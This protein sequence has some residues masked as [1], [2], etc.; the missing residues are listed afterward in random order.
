[1]NVFR[2]FIL[3]LILISASIT[4]AG[5]RAL[6]L[7]HDPELDNKD[8]LREIDR[9]IQNKHFAE[10][11]QRLI[12]LFPDKKQRSAD[13]WLRLGICNS[14]V[15]RFQEAGDCFQAG[16][17]LAPKDSRL[18]LN[19]ALLYDRENRKDDEEALLLKLRKMD[20]YF[21]QVCFHLGRL[22]EERGDLKTADAYY[23]E[24]LNRDPASHQAWQRHFRLTREASAQETAS[25]SL[26]EVN[27]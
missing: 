22:A 8:A 25:A 16:L 1:M 27:Q 26:E 15:E 24:E 5:G 13:I 20:P 7:I 11:E 17:R 2:G 19:V 4:V 21:P 14:M 12:A 10:A 18:L 23:V 3:I 6:L 9:Q